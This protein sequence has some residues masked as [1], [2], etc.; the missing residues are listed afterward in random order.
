M[1]KSNLEKFYFFLKKRRGVEKKV[2]RLIRER[3]FKL[4]EKE[5]NEENENV[6]KMEIKREKVRG[7]KLRKS[8]AFD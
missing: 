4:K 1:K 5:K 6:D 8:M 3:T 2:W 7:L